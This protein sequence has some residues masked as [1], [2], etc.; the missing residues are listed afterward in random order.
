M[1]LENYVIYESEKAMLAMAEA[2]KCPMVN[3][4]NDVHYIS[5]EST[6]ATLEMSIQYM[7]AFEN[8][9]TM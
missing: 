5:E 9:Y 2:F 6:I 8:I 3:I 4:P 7:V 1:I